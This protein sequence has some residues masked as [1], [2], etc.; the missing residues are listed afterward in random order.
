MPTYTAPTTRSS[1]FLVTAA[2]YNTDLVEN[3][4]YFKDAPTFDGAVTASTT[5]AVGTGLTYT[6]SVKSTTALATPGALSA[7]QATAFASTVSGA[8][9]MGFGTTNDVS[10]MNRAGTVVLGVGPNTTTI[11]MTGLLTVSGFGQNTFS[12]GGN[13]T[14]SIRVE[15]TSAGTAAVA[16]FNA[17]NDSTW[18]GGFRVLSSTYT[19][20]GPDIAEGANLHWNGSGGLSIAATNASGAIRFYSGG[21]TK[22]GEFSVNGNLIVNDATDWSRIAVKG[23]LAVRDHISLQDSGTL[24]AS[25]SLYLNFYNSTGGTA[26]SIQHTSASGVTYSTA[27]DMRL[28]E[29]LGLASDLSGLRALRVHDF[30]WKDD[31]D[32]IDRNV[33]AQEAYTALPGRGAQPGRLSSGALDLNPEIITGTWMV[34]KAGYVPDLIVGWQQHDATIQSLAARI[35][36]LEAGA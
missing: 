3:I 23:S 12:A 11:N 27:S 6:T 22:V 25:T 5:L 7:T 34:E 2:V 33:F 29:D 20:S 35:A 21:S 26:G 13:Q 36:A 17:R 18:N 4:K 15:N 9:I 10:L 8:A 1:G 28:K 14:N 32:R 30:R 16:A 24:Y 31:D 19:T